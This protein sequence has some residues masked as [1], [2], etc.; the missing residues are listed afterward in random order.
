MNGDYHP[1]GSPS[2]ESGRAK[3]D[4][5]ELRR[6]AENATKGEWQM[7]GEPDVGMPATVFTGSIF[8][9]DRPHRPVWD[10]TEDMAYIV[11]AQPS[12]VLALLDRI[13][14]LKGALEQYA[15]E[16][17]W[18]MRGRFNPEHSQFDGTSFARKALSGEKP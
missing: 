9:S 15:D 4:Y 13:E 8:S 14:E 2:A 1:V 6:K 5:A 18:R 12:T 10:D 16:S 17:N 11:A 3:I 7:Y